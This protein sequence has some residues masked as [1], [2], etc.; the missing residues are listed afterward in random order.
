ML[1]QPVRRESFNITYGEPVRLIRWSVH[2]KNVAMFM[3][4]DF[5]AHGSPR[6]ENLHTGSVA[7]GF[8]NGFLQSTFA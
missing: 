7:A 1:P 4:R 8:K 3:T 2:H 5:E 6:T